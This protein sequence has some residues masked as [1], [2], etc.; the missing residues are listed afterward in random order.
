MN[1]AT[2]ADYKIILT[3]IEMINLASAIMTIWF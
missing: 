3:K 1:F 2:L